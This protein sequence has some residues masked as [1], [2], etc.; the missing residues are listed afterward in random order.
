MHGYELKQHLK[1][2]TGHFRPVSDGALYPAISRLKKQGLIVQTTETG[3]VAAPRHVLSLTIAGKEELLDRLKKPSEHDISDRNRFF[4][5]LSFL[6]Y[7]EPEYQIQVLEKRLEF[8][9][10]GKS[11]FQANGQPVSTAAETDSFR[12]GMLIIARETS[13]VERSWLKEMIKELKT[14]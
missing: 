4:T 10:G 14:R 12:K 6:R 9:E 3:K 11:F 5:F 13:K 8:L 1:M 2:L 7:L